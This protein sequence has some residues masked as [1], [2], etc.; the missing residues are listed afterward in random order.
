LVS[1]GLTAPASDLYRIISNTGF[2]FV[3]R[4]SFLDDDA[5]LDTPA[6]RLCG[7]FISHGWH[8]FGMNLAGA[9]AWLSAAPP[10]PFPINE[11]V[12]LGCHVSSAQGIWRKVLPAGLKATN[13]YAEGFCVAHDAFPTKR[14]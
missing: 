11:T 5:L 8:H 10:L 2:I 3:Q 4:P 6:L 7:D 1:S 13:V 12:L 9:R 14:R